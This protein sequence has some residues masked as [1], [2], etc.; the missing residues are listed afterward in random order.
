CGFLVPPKSPEALASKIAYL[1]RNEDDR[2]RFGQANRQIIKEKNSYEGEMEKM[3]KLYEELIE[4]YRR[5]G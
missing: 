4:R 5:C 3:G 2:I 1:L